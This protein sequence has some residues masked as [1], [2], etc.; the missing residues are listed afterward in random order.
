MYVGF[1]PICSEYLGIK[2]PEYNELM[3]LN[4]ADNG[5]LAKLLAARQQLEAANNVEGSITL[6]GTR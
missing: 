3:G 1:G 6:E 2:R 5:Q 4:P